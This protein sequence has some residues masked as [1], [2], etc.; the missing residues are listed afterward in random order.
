M[1]LASV[2]VFSWGL[3]QPDILSV[4]ELCHHIAEAWVSASVLASGVVQY[5]R[6]NPGTVRSTRRFQMSAF[7]YKK[8][9]DDLRLIPSCA[10]L[11]QFCVLTCAVSSCLA[12]V[13]SY[14]PG[15]VLSYSAGESQ[16]R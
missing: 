11:H 6:R 1:I 7:K 12:M 10:P 3:V 14:I 2:F 16:R 13:G 15:L 8:E 4:P 9:I 5:K